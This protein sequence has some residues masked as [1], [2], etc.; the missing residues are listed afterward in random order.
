VAAKCAELGYFHFTPTYSSW[1]NQVERWFADL[2]MKQLRRGTHRSTL[3]LEAAIKQHLLIY[4]ENPKPFVWVK[5][6]DEILTSIM[7][8]CTRIS[9]TGH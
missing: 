1:I 5:S 4:N 9:E 8:V 6:A 2:T 7:R 3:A